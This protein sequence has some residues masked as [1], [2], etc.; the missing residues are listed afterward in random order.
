MLSKMTSVSRQTLGIG[1]IVLIAF[2]FLSL[3]LLASA[4][5]KSAQL[6]LTADSLFTVSDGTKEVLASVDEPIHLRFYYSKQFDELSPF[7]SNHAG[8][9]RD[10]LE[11]YV[12]LSRDKVQVEYYDP[13]PF[14][15][16]ED[17]AVADGLQGI[18]LA[19]DGA[20]AY[21]GLAG[22]NSTDDTEAIAY[23]APERA[24]F[25]EYDLTRLVHDLANPEKT[26]VGVIGNLPLNGSQLNR[27]QRWA[28]LESMEQFFDLRFLYG[29]IDTIDDNVGILML[30]QPQD[31][32]EKSLYAIDQFVMRRGRILAFLDPYSEELAGSRPGMAPQEDTAIGTLEPLLAAWGVE[33]PEGK[34]VG[35]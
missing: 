31:L 24:N 32:D 11:T 13:Q 26:V 18:T 22:S 4:V 5:F 8:R 3:N 10:L 33:I 12:D 23:L 14:S 30:A 16:E 35:D 29:S 19:G 27:F 1:G 34:I 6:D 7:Y 28:V 9:L 25:L 21:F 15:P 20:Q 17:L 2:F